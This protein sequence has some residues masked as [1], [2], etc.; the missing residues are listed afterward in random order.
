MDVA[1]APAAQRVVVTRPDET[2]GSGDA[3]GPEQAVER[4]AAAVGK[5]FDRPGFDTLREAQLAGQ[6]GPVVGGGTSGPEAPASGATTASPLAFRDGACERV[7]LIEGG[8]PASTG[9]AMLSNRTAAALTAAVGSTVEYRG[10]GSRQAQRLT[11][12]GIY[13]PAD[14]YDAYWTGLIAVARAGEA[15]EGSR[16]ADDA[17]IVTLPTL[18]ASGSPDVNPAIYQIATPQ[19][20]ADATP[21]RVTRSFL[22]AQYYL[23][24]DGYH[25]QGE[26]PALGQRIERDQRLVYVA[27]PAGAAQLLLL[28]W[29]ALYLAVTF[30]GHQRRPDAGLLKLHG[31]GRG[32]TWALIAGQTALPMLAGA[33]VGLAAGYA[34]AVAIAGAID[35]PGQERLAAGLAVAGAAGAVLGGLLVAL[36]AELRT[37]R[38]SVVDLLR[39]VPSRRRGWRTDVLDLV[40]VALALA[41]VYQTATGSSGGLA[42][43]A[44]GLLALAIGLIAARA[45]VEIAGRTGARQLREGRVA[46]GLIATGLAR[47][48]GTHR[49]FALLTVVVAGLGTAVLGWD[50]ASRAGTERA[51][52]ELGADRVLTVQAPSRGRLLAAVRAAD[53]GGTAAMAVVQTA[54]TAGTVPVL[55]VDATRLHAVARWRPEYGPDPSPLLRP[56]G[57]EPVILTGERL[58]LSVT[59]AAVPAE[60]HILATLAGPQGERIGAEFGPITPQSKEYEAPA[61]C[62]PGCRLVSLALTGATGAGGTRPAAAPGTDIVVHGLGG[63]PAEL[64]TDRT[65]WRPSL[66]QGGVGLTIARA[67]DGLRLFAETVARRPDKHADTRAFLVDAPVPLP[68][69]AAGDLPAPPLA[70]DLRLDAV[71][72]G[73]LPV[74]VAGRAGLLPRLGASGALVDLESA[75]RAGADFGSGD[76]M[77]VWLT[78]T[79]ASSIVDRL[80]AEGVQVLSDEALAELAGRYAREGTPVALRFQLLAA[81]VGVLLGA[82]VVAVVAAVER[83]PR[84][85]ELAALRVQGAPRRTVRRVA[86]VG[87]AV[88]VGLSTVVGILAAL[89]A[90]LVARAPLPVFADGW[91]LLPAAPPRGTILALAAA[92][93]LAVFAAVV[94]ALGLRLARRAP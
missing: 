55:A 75:D 84:A 9:E 81:L 35:Q 31:T 54:A 45:A 30:T 33:V 78:R 72:G 93:L 53:P 74:Q 14:P 26:L 29:F 66:D 23:Q 85:A 12:T 63:A 48:P 88:L 17:I 94:A 13:R 15:G 46:A 68:V 65:R 22:F 89:A 47:R 21:K 4:L 64:F 91:R 60:L 90:W 2:A 70:G 43:L 77:Q 61:R 28:C 58:R 11:V 49:V 52:A 10:P 86:L 50:G 27:V 8:C 1:A 37:M 51:A 39:A 67:A 83:E 18:A 5:H 34:G 92:G 56:A 3:G 42:L 76:V 57:P 69:L 62:A 80:A 79:A 44:P 73:A 87:Y 7:R 40:A 59:A 20:F 24:I 16:A 6:A 41:G 32:R 25:M 19:A 71:G 36:G 38:A 82:G